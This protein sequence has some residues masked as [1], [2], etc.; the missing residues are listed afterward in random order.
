[1]T[2]QAC[3]CTLARTGF[4][5]IMEIHRMMR[6]KPA[7]VLLVVAG[8]LLSACDRY[9]LTRSIY[10]GRRATEEANKDTP[11]G[12]PHGTSLSYDDYMKARK[13]LS[14]PDSKSN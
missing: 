4:A 2:A 3:C 12:N 13:A 14:D 10:E 9:P 1:M 11:G 8:V 5:I 7:L 6:K